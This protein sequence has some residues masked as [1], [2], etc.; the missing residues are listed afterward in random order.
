MAIAGAIIGAAVG[1]RLNDWIGRKP[2]ILAADLLFAVGAF[3]M[4]AAPNPYCLI[5]G[6][7]LVG[8]GVGVASM[9]A[10][11]YIAEASP[12][13]IRGALVC[14]N[15]LFITGGQFLSYLINLAFTK[16]L[17]RLRTSFMLTFFLSENPMPELSF[18]TTT[19]M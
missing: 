3:V 12:A 14:V 9:T 18:E 5:A 7:I 6:R 13:Q 8:I 11:L 16:V 2:S 4:A 19:D 17:F 15:V 1:G 10:P